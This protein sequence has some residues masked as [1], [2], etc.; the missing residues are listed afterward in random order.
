MKETTKKLKMTTCAPNQH[1]FSALDLTPSL[2][3]NYSQGVGQLGAQ[4]TKKFIL[5][6]S[7]CGEVRSL[8]L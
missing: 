5:Y 4:L 2:Y 1:N 3:G 7:K 8:G 6:C